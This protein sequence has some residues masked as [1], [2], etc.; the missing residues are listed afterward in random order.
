MERESDA[1]HHH[2]EREMGR[3]RLGR[4]CTEFAI[5]PSARDDRVGQ[6]GGRW[7]ALFTV[8][9][10]EDVFKILRTPT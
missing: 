2:Y 10:E 6:C 4:D 5:S 1:I 8:E 7:M 3:A 9:V